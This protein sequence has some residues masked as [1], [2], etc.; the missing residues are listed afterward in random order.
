MDQHSPEGESQS[1]VGQNT[2]GQ[3]TARAAAGLDFSN[4]KYANTI[5]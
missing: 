4:Q 2:I 1:Q 3:R 5:A